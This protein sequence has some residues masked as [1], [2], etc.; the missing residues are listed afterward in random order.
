MHQSLTIARLVGPV[1]AAIGIG[2]LVNQ[3]VYRQMAGQFL[4]GY[5]FIYFSGFW[6]WSPASTSSTCTTSGRATGAA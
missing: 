3:D 1:L 6:R 5:A 2:M 4:A